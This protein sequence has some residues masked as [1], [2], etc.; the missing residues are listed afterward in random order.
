MNHYISI[1][2]T[3][4]TVNVR[5][6]RGLLMNKHIP[7][8]LMVLDD[9]MAKRVEWWTI[10]FSKQFYSWTKI[11][12][13]MKIR[14]KLYWNVSELDITKTKFPGIN[15]IDCVCRNIAIYCVYWNIA[16]I[17]CGLQKPVRIVW[18]E[19][20]FHVFWEGCNNITGHNFSPLSHC[21]GNDYVLPL[22]FGREWPPYIRH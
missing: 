2:R 7:L 12:W 21:H 8:D 18:A 16:Y 9:Q 13:V 1:R 5:H 14:W 4:I 19:W 20:S 3:S 22:L 10:F 15:C 11:Y 17:L 6:R